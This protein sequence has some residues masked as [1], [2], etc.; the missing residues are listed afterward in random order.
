MAVAS[1]E[2]RLAVEESL[3]SAFEMLL[4]DLELGHLESEKSPDQNIS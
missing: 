4:V 3:K 2:N 1:K